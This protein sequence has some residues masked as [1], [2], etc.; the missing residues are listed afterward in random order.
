MAVKEVPEK[1]DGN[2]ADLYVAALEKEIHM[3][4]QLSHRNIVR[5]IGTQRDN[6]NLYIVCMMCVSFL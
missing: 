6:N 1:K 3:L 5:Y 2:T 4:S